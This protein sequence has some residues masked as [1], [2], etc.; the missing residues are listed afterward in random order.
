MGQSTAF[1][2]QVTCLIYRKYTKPTSMVEFIPHLEVRLQ[3][4]VEHHPRGVHHLIQRLTRMESL[5]RWTHP[6]RIVI[7][8]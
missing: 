3:T 8:F 6:R 7:P 5:R 2:N 4:T 1:M